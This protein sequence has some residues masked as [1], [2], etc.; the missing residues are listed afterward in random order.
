MNGEWIGN[1]WWGATPHASPEHNRLSRK[2]TLLLARADRCRSGNMVRLY[3]A[4]T[5][6]A[7]IVGARLDELNHRR[8]AA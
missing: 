2:M 1:R 5:D 8:L 3:C 6:A 7:A 4:Y